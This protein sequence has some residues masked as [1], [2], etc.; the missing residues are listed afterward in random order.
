MTGAGSGGCGRGCL[1]SWLLLP[2]RTGRTLELSFR[3][4]MLRPSSL[5]EEENE[6]TEHSLHTFLLRARIWAKGLT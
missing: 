4:E 5:T 6:V 1:P 3:R 2:G